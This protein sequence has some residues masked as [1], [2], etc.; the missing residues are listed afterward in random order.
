MGKRRE[1]DSERGAGNDVVFPMFVRDKW[2]TGLLIREEAGRVARLPQGGVDA[3]FRADYYPDFPTV[4]IV[5]MARFGYDYLHETEMLYET[6]INPG[7]N[8]P[9]I[10]D[11]AGGS[12]L[13]VIFY[14]P[15]RDRSL[16]FPAQG[17]SLFF[18]SLVAGTNPPRF[19]LPLRPG[20]FEQDRGQVY[21][22]Y[23]TPGR[24]WAALR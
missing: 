24:L 11:L 21:R 15:G 6:W 18:S 19:A 16:M 17:L 2:R 1:R 8:Y 14:T 3:E 20:D 13:P 9:S 4:P 10:F 22:E 5:I 12:G 23:P 7:E